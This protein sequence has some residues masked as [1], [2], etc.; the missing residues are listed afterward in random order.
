VSEREKRTATNEALFREV[1]ERLEERVQVL[2]GDHAPFAVLC[3]CSDCECTERIMLTAAEYEETHSDS[4]Q[5]IV[6]EGHVAGDV[7]DVVA[8]KDRFVVVRKRGLAGEIA[9][10]LD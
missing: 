2:V 7:E 10:A 6:V 4:A 1:N 5:F 3:E 9:E 8:R